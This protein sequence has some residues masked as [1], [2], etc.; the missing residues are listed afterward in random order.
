VN[1]TGTGTG[2][3]PDGKADSGPLQLYER[4][5]STGE[6]RPDE[7]QLVVVQHLQKV[8]DELDSYKHQRESDGL[9]SGVSSVCTFFYIAISRVALMLEA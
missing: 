5:L 2:T 4:R 7:N 3:T 8:S 6:L 1:D 9:F